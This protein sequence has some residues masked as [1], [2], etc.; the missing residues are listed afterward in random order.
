MTQQSCNDGKC[1]IACEV[2]SAHVYTKGAPGP[3]S[4]TTLMNHCSRSLMVSR[5]T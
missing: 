3:K 4:S 1:Q 2:L 5:Y